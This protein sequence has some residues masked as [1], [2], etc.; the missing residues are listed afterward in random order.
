MELEDLFLDI[1]K[2]L[3]KNFGKNRIERISDT[4][5]MY[6]FS[7]CN[8]PFSV[9]VY[10][11]KKIIK[12]DIWNKKDNNS[13]ECKNDKKLDSFKNQYRELINAFMNKKKKW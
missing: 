10:I 4:L 13:I 3:K 7:N 6:H 11:D 1:T 8:I 2:D 12:F 5:Y 9:K